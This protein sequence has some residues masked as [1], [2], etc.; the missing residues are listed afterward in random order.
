MWVI[1]IKICPF[2]QTENRDEFEYCI[3]CH[4]H[5]IET[6]E[7]L[8]I[9]DDLKPFIINENSSEQSLRAGNGHETLA[10]IMI[11]GF[12]AI[13]IITFILWQLNII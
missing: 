9:P 1:F 4:A 2:C 6:D 7:N 10:N 12:I 8:N 5:F 13:V 3:H 11:Y